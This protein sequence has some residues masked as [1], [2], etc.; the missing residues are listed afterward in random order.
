MTAPVCGKSS[1]VVSSSIAGM[2]AAALPS[3]CQIERINYYTAHISGRWSC[4]S[5]RRLDPAECLLDRFAHPL[6]FAI[7]R[8]SRCV[9]PETRVSRASTIRTRAVLHQPV[10]DKTKLASMPGPLR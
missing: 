9:Q 3:N 4:A 2:S 8:M 5:R 6:A 10:A 7:A 1:R